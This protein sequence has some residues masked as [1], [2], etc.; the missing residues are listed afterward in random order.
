MA[1]LSLSN[2]HNTSPLAFKGDFKG[3][4]QSMSNGLL[5]ENERNSSADA[6]FSFCQKAYFQSSRR[7]GRGLIEEHETSVIVQEKD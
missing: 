7:R 1:H 4:S 6:P 3:F 5:F 2:L